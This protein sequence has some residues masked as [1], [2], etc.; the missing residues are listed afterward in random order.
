MD[1]AVRLRL[2]CL[3]NCGLKFRLNA[4]FAIMNNK[5]YCCKCMN[6]SP[7]C[8]L[9]CIHG[10]KITLLI[11]DSA[12]GQGQKCLLFFSHDCFVS[13]KVYEK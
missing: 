8:V 1:S 13:Y 11:N 4:C 5:F 7:V 6:N 12:G 10:E 2:N 9:F 3:K